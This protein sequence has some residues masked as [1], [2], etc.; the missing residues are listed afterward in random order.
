MCNCNV[1]DV[2]DRVEQ[3]DDVDPRRHYA[4]TISDRELTDVERHAVDCLLLAPTAGG[5][6][7]AATLPLLSRMAREGWAGTSVLSRPYRRRG[8]RRVRR[9]TGYGQRQGLRADPPW[10]DPLS[11]TAAQPGSAHQIRRLSG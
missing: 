6:T 7:E 2:L 3:F 10:A 8:H 11:R 5:K 1:V 9:P 4:L